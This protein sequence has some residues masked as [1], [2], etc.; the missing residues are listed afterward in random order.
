MYRAGTTPQTL[1]IDADGRVGY[2]HLGAV[3]DPVVIDSILDA[4]ATV[5]AP[6]VVARPD[7]ATAP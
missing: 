1:I 7:S 3:T 2:S 4:V 5:A 6:A